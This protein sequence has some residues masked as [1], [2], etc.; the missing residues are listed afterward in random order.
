MDVEGSEGVLARLSWSSLLLAEGVRGVSEH[1]MQ[2]QH[3]ILTSNVKYIHC[4][5]ATWQRRGRRLVMLKQP[6]HQCEEAAAAAGR[7]AHRV[8]QKH[9]GK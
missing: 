6:V 4:L 9:N 3:H 1:T 2:K 7:V 5:R 8:S